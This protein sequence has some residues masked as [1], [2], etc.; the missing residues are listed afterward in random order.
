M[1]HAPEDRFLFYKHLR[2]LRRRGYGTTYIHIQ[3]AAMSKR[4]AEVQGDK[5]GW[6]KAIPG[7]DANGTAMPARATASQ[8][9]RRK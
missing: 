8:M 2:Y 3:T 4:A 1:T 5:N 6:F 7:S 9:A